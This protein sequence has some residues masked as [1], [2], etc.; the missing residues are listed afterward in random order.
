MKY[1]FDN[2]TLT[3][4]IFTL[5]NGNTVG[6]YVT[7]WVSVSGMFDWMLGAMHID[8]DINVWSNNQ[9]QQYIVNE[10]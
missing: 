5:S 8:D 4:P 1:K 2:I 7:I 3:D 10:T 6:K 9:L